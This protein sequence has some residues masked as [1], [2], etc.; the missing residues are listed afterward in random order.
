MG[1]CGSDCSGFESILYGTFFL[2]L[3]LSIRNFNTLEDIKIFKC[4]TEEFCTVEQQQNTN[5]KTEPETA[6]EY[7]NTY[8]K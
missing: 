7:E 6:K 1:E 4:D 5:T 3:I 2:S 8:N